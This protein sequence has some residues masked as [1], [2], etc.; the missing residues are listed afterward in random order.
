MDRDGQRFLRK[1]NISLK[2]EF[3]KGWS[4]G[5]QLGINLEAML[6][7]GVARAGQ[8]L[9]QCKARPLEPQ[10]VLVEG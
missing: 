5:L 6:D 3:E 4:T 1:V 10:G 9:R 8:I 7:S 2:E